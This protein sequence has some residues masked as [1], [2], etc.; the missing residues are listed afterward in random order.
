MECGC[1]IILTDA[2][3]P[4]QRSSSFIPTNSYQ[5]QQGRITKIYPCRMEL[6]VL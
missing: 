2:V 5:L 4:D 1:G 3:A 6:Q